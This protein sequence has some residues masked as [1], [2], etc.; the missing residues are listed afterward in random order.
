MLLVNK[1]TKYN[2]T[3]NLSALP[4]GAIGELY[5][6]GVGLARGYLNNPKLTEER[7]IPN[8]FQTDL[9][10]RSNIN[11]RLYKTGD[12]VRW[13]EDGNLE[14]IGRNDFQVK[15]RGFR[16]ELGE[17]ETV[18]TDYSDI[19]QVAVLAKENKETSNKYLVAYYISDNGE[20]LNEEDVLVYLST[21]L[22]EYMVP[23][24]IVHIDE[25]PLTVNGK[26]DRKALPDPLLGSNDDTYTAPGND[27]ETKLC[28]IFAGVLGLDISKIGIN[29]DFFRLGGNSILAIKLVNKIIKETS[30]IINIADI[31]SYKN[32]KRLAHHLKTNIGKE[33]I[34]PISRITKLEK[35]SLSFAQERLFFIDKYEQGTNAY[36]IPIIY[37]LNDNTNILSLRKALDSVVKRQQVLC[38][39]IQEDSDGNSFQYINKFHNK[40][41]KEVTVKSIGEVDILIAKDINYIFSLSKEYP[42]KVRI[43]KLRNSKKKYISII[44]H[45][46]AFDGWSTDI[47]FNEVLQYYNYY[48]YNIKLDLPDL[49]I[50]Y[51]DFAL[52][53]RKY[54]TDKVLDEQV[55]YWKKELDG[56]ENINL[57][58]DH[59][60]SLKLDYKGNNITFSLDKTLS[61]NLRNTAKK[62]GV[63]LYTL[64]LG[65]YY[66]MLRSY[67]NQD[68]IVIGTPVANR[69][70]SQ[71][72]NLIGFFVNTLALRININNFSKLT[73]FIKKLGD[74]VI[75]AQLHQDLPFEKLVYELNVEKD[76]SR[77]PI[78]QIMFGLQAFGN[79]KSDDKKNNIVLPYKGNTNQYTIAK[80]DIETFMDDSEEIIRG[81]FNYR[82]TLY[83]KDTIENFIN[84]FLQILKQVS[85]ITSNENINSIQNLK[86]LNKDQE[87]LILKKWNDT[88][89]PYPHNKTIHTLFEEQ[90]LKTPNNIAVVYEDIKLTYKEL[91]ERS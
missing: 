30:L 74:Q 69:H 63:S 73:E 43:Y 27:L 65:S 25:F 57:L 33:I 10:K 41:C 18:L 31:F 35:Q 80:F 40:Y 23:T 85:V 89:K 64:L 53:Q 28:N 17:I 39:S 50:Q 81:S 84:T 20:K 70:Y 29:N 83:K 9:E 59:S 56:Y 11:T 7:F 54:L 1:L 61:N 79:N 75:E 66:L 42:I 87:E 88:D 34:I 76:T 24:A 38:T 44:I 21:K 19:K 12:L 2:N 5:I 91:N 68:N 14:Y 55:N 45:H 62:L 49:S 37:R 13:L 3:V 86:Y 47:F 26:L 52:W 6:G 46:I 90:V 82:V 4:I 22:P 51:K 78:F 32:I 36:N 16:I 72:E 58:T 8:P 60:R 67:T 15:I 77:H 48:T 71:I